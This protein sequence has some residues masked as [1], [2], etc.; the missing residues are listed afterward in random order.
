MV[1]QSSPGFSAGGAPVR[2]TSLPGTR[3]QTVMLAAQAGS[4][5]DLATLIDAPE[6]ARLRT[7]RDGGWAFPEMTEMEQSLTAQFFP[8]QGGFISGWVVTEVTFGA[9]VPLEAL[10][11][12]GSAGRPEWGRGWW[13]AIAE[14]VCF[15]APPGVDV[16]AGVA[17]YLA[18]RWKFGGHPATPAQRK[19]AIAAGLNY[20]VDWATIIS[21]R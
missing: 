19:A 3:V 18:L 20:G 2:F 15:D 9:P 12:G 16:R 21:I 8:G 1:F 6:T 14:A 13:G 17:N 11:F 10:R 4:P 7:A 5:A